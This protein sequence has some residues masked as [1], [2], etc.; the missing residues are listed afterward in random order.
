MKQLF[1]NIRN[2][3]RNAMGEL[4]RQIYQHMNPDA[5]KGRFTQLYNKYNIQDAD[6]D[7][8][9]QK[10]L[11]IIL[12]KILFSE[13]LNS[14]QNWSEMSS[15]SSTIC[16]N[17]CFELLKRRGIFIEV[18]DSHT[19]QEIS[20]EISYIDLNNE[21]SCMVEQMLDLL[22]NTCQKIIHLEFLGKKNQEIFS[23]LHEDETV[24]LQDTNAI[25]SKKN[26]CKTQL[27]DR[28]REDARFNRWYD[29]FQDF[30]LL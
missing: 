26:K 6:R 27:K 7:D 24:S 23:I 12:E 15:Y 16:K 29:C 3:D 17:L 2:G 19:F 10:I 28:V 18:E 8:I 13:K 11:L 21:C 30:F 25:R 20:Q 14:M 9:N 1:E 4:H 22:S 5:N